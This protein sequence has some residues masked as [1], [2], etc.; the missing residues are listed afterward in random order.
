M[1][2][3]KNNMDHSAERPNPPSVQR[4]FTSLVPCTH[5]SKG[6]NGKGEGTGSKVSISWG[7]IMG[8]GTGSLLA[9]LNGFSP[10][11]STGFLWCLFPL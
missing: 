6:R 7:H 4:H 1:L 10:I 5:P 3:G 8:D 9:P 2:V 11:P